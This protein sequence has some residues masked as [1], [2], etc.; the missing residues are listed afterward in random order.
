MNLEPFIDGRVLATQ[1]VEL[2]ADDVRYIDL[3][4]GVYFNFFNIYFREIFQT[5]TM[6][7]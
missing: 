3:T 6:L 4:A 7:S 5:R 2:T 1:P